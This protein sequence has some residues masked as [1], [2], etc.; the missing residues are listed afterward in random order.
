MTERFVRRDPDVLRDQ[1]VRN[2]REM[3]ADHCNTQ[4]EF[5][6]FAAPH[7]W[8]VPLAWDDR[9]AADGGQR[10]FHIY[11]EE[12]IAHDDPLHWTGREHNWNYMCAECHSTNL[13]KN[14]DSGSQTFNSTWSEINVGCEGCHGPGSQHLAAATAG[15]LAGAMSLLVDLDDTGRAVWKMNTAS[16]IAERTE[17]RTRPPQQP[18]SC[19]RCHSRRAVIRRDYAYGQPLLD[20]HMPAL[21]DENLY[22]A[23]G[24]IK[25]EVYVWGSFLQSR[26]YQAG[27]TCTDCH[28]PHTASLKT[29]GEPSN[30]CATCH[31]PSR[32]ASR[33]HHQ[34]APE[35]VVCLDCHMPSRNYM[36][37]DGRRDHSFRLPRPDLTIAT[38]S[39]NACNACHAEQGP[40]WANAKLND[41]YDDARPAHYAVAIHAGRS[42]AAGAN[43]LLAGAAHNT[44]FPGI[45]RATA[46][47][48]ITP[49]LNSTSIGAI[50][51]GLINADALIRVGAL[52]AL[53]GIPGETRLL[54]ASPMRCP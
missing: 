41:W 26:M 51:D 25:D 52:R 15:T 49:P 11:G 36:V 45:A 19:G 42:T 4:V 2:T 28:D 46:L 5:G 35:Q 33:D 20:T 14:F 34:H 21:L 13:Q 31:L 39:P 54:A 50:R 17:L 37:I 6:V 30:V 24:Q 48:L 10:W 22:F 53:Q 27:V 16:G 40:E 18:E 23:D 3:T 12:S 47:S 43:S 44:T 32:F 29:A 9:D 1:R 8:V 7:P 38:G